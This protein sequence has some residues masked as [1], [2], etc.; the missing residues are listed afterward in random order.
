M[1]HHIAEEVFLTPT[2][3]HPSCKIIMWEVIG[4]ANQAGLMAGICQL[5][6]FTH[7]YFLAAASDQA[8]LFRQTHSNKFTVRH[9]HFSIAKRLQR[10]VFNLYQFP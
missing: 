2:A 10:P 5:A 9:I 7:P 6:D 4:G 3:E 1:S 8:A